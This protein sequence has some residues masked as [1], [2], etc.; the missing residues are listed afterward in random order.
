MVQK[1]ECDRQV[2]RFFVF[3]ENLAF[4]VCRKK[5]DNV[6]FPKKDAGI[7]RATRESRLT[8]HGATLTLGGH[9][10]GAGVKR[11]SPQRNFRKSSRKELLESEIPATHVSH[12]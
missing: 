2:E 4:T 1:T 5:A 10:F 8:N 12:L 3:G 7:H 9:Q 6:A 11:D